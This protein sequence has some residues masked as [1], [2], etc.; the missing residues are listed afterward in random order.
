M[1]IILEH[2]V[3]ARNSTLG[4]SYGIICK[5]QSNIPKDL[6]LSLR[7]TEK[8]KLFTTWNPD[9]ACGNGL[10]GL[11]LFIIA[12]LY[13]LFGLPISS[14]GSIAWFSCYDY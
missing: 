10:V 7:Q 11:L 13:G 4:S 2:A 8:L 14:N 1:I 9:L 5:I 6:L 3:D 12:K